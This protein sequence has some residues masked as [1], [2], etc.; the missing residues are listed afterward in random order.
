MV[1]KPFGVQLWLWLK[2]VG[3]VCVFLTFVLAHIIDITTAGLVAAFNKGVFIIAEQNSLLVRAIAYGDMV[4]FLIVE[5]ISVSFITL[6][7]LCIFRCRKFIERF[8]S[9]N[10]PGALHRQ[11]TMYR[12]VVFALAFVVYIMAFFVW[13]LPIAAG[14]N[15]VNGLLM[16]QL[17]YVELRIAYVLV[18]LPFAWALTRFGWKIKDW[19]IWPIMLTTMILASFLTF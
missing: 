1:K 3:P 6:L 17:G 9:A 8:I 15:I 10:A 12:F 19:R 4:P 14:T 18:A 13:T 11:T 2:R 5:I 16:L 7:I